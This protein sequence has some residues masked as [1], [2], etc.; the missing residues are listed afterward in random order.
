MWLERAAEQGASSAFGLL[1]DCY[2][3]G[4]CGVPVNT[5]KA[6][7]WRHRME[8]YERRHPVRPSRRYS[9]DGTVSQ[10]SLDRL[11]AIE[12]VTGFGFLAGDRHLAVFY[13][14]EAISPAEL[15]E[16]IRAAGL[17]DLPGE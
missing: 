8:E 11:L 10:S 17:S 13:E 15:D 16:K 6:Q 12:G 7:L 4:F 14:R 5:A 1:V 9:V 3:N 2:S